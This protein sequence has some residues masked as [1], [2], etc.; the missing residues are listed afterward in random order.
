M[1]Q[2]SILALKKFLCKRSLSVHMEYHGCKETATGQCVQK[3]Y[4]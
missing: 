2:I 3:N 1:Q 4:V